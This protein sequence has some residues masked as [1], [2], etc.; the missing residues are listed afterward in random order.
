MADR[1]I[2]LGIN[3]TRDASACLMRGSEPPWAVPTERPTRRNGHLGGVGDVGDL[4]EL[5][6]PGKDG[7]VDIPAGSHEAATSSSPS[8]RHDPFPLA[9]RDRSIDVNTNEYR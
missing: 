1:A 9:G 5:Q 6:L 2:V 8:S 7:L 4:C 3:R